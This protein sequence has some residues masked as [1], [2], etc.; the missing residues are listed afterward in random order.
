M[1][2]TRGS[3]FLAVIIANPIFVTSMIS[4]VSNPAILSHTMADENQ[5]EII[6]ILLPSLS[7]TQATQGLPR[8]AY[9]ALYTRKIVLASPNRPPPA[10]EVQAFH[11]PTPSIKLSMEAALISLIIVWKK[12]YITR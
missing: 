7:D 8:T 9:G 12:E 1:N 3:N 4:L 5:R 11:F 6:L 10:G 2:T